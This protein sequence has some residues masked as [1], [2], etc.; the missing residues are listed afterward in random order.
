MR[1]ILKNLLFTLAV[2]GVVAGWV[3]WRLAAG[4][5]SMDGWHLLVALA[6]FAVGGSV[7]G[8][9]VWDFAAF[10]RGTPLPIDAPKK[11]VVR[12]LYRWVRN[13]MYL[14]VLAVVA[15]WAVLYRSAGLALY[16]VLLWTVFHAFVFFY[17]EP[18]L[19][20]SFGAEYEAYKMQVGRW[21]PRLGR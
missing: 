21:L 1:L 12:G 4:R 14:G 15:G 10:G 9:C 5:A 3:P 17:E 13:P 18:A 16:L 20:R 8:W 2:P 7:Y 19:G 6:L 11:L